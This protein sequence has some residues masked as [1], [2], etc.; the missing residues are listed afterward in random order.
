MNYILLFVGILIWI[1]ILFGIR[2][3]AAKNHSYWSAFL[4]RPFGV[5]MPSMILGIVVRALFIAVGTTAI[6]KFMI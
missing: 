3:C 4:S 2:Y 5:P 1:E 6:V